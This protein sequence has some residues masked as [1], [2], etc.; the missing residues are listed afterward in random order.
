MKPKDEDLRCSLA[1]FL[2]HVPVHGE[3]SI[4]EAE[5]LFRRYVAVDMSVEPVGMIR[6]SHAHRSASVEF[7]LP[8]EQ[9]A[10]NESKPS[11]RGLVL[12]RA[13]AGKEA[14]WARQSNAS[15]VHCA[16]CVPVLAA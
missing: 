8:C 14:R 9:R 16:V 4:Q 15:G 11:A 7:Q 3:A 10:A 13:A 12:L 5:H 2:Q 6:R 1:I